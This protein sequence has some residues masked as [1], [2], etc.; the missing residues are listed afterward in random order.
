MAV[1]PSPEAWDVVH[2]HCSMFKSNTGRLGS[3]LGRQADRT[4]SSIR[5]PNHLLFLSE[6]GLHSHW[7][8]LP[9]FLIVLQ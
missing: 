1:S 6:S 3:Q 9:E 8:K 2:V 5:Y 7:F 4:F